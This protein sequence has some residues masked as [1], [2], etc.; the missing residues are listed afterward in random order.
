MLPYR[1]PRGNVNLFTEQLESS[2]SKMENDRTIKDNILTGDLNID[3]IKFDINNNTNE[4]LNTVIKNGHIPTILLPTRVTSHT[5]TLIDH[6]F[7][8]S[9]NARIQAAQ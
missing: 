8:L 5:C 6:I 7:Y 3:L 9:R 4:Y 1:H 2:L